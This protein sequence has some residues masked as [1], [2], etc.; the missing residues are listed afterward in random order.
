[1]YYTN[2]VVPI[3]VLYYDFNLIDTF[4]ITNNL[5]YKGSDSLLHDVAGRTGNPFKLKTITIAAALPK[6]TLDYGTGSVIFKYISQ[7]FL[8][9]KGVT[10]TSIYADFGTG[11][12]NLTSG[13]TVTISYPTSGM[14]TIKFTITYS[15]SQTATVYSKYIFVLSL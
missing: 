11:N 8:N 5:F 9:N 10:I 7:L 4:A 6:D 15:N 13:N 1:M 14:K 2:S 3:G 12:Q